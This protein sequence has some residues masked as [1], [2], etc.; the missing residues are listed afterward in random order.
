M[1]NDDFKRSTANL[2]K[3][4]PLMMKNHVAA[5]PSNY[6]LWYTYVDNVIPQLN[7]ELDTVLE[8]FGLCPPATSSQLY[9]HYVASRSET[10]LNQLRNNIEVLVNEVA[11]SMTDTL[12]DTSKFAKVIDKSFSELERVEDDELSIEEVMTLVRQLV[13]ESR[14]IRH[15]TRFLNG[16]LNNASQE[17]QRLKE[18]LAEVQKGALFDGLSGLYNRRSFNDDLNVLISAQ[19][20]ISLILLDIDHFKS[21]ND[22]YGHLFGDTVIKGIAKRLQ[23][24]SRDGITAYRFGG[25]EFVLIVPNKTL[26]IAR[27]FAESLRRSLEKL[28]VKDRRSGK[29]VG[30]ITASFGV[31]EWQLGDTSETL[32]ERADSLL[33]EAKQLGRNRVMPL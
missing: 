1:T 10:N 12:T 13:T 29:L 11:S 24:T 4:V 21:F 19:Q 25:E 28:S 33:Y 7:Q 8:N 5:T 30:N 26:R 2:K 15:S 20:P 32:I 27:Q 22:N 14:D 3:A 9:N 16:Q 17:I 31:A 6:A 23:S 18:Q